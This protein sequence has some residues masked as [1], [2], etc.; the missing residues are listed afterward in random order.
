MQKAKTIESPAVAKIRVEKR[1][2]MKFDDNCRKFNKIE[3][4]KVL[5]NIL[6]QCEK[7]MRAA[8]KELNSSKVDN[9]LQY[10]NFMA[11]TNLSKLNPCTMDYSMFKILQQNHR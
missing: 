2:Q 3:N 11:D 9:M 5:N 6:I 1:L 10:A 4:G 7:E 8:F